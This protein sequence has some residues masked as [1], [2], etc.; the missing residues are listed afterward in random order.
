MQ[1]REEKGAGLCDMFKEP[2]TQAG[3]FL[4]LH[5]IH[6]HTHNSTE[7]RLMSLSGPHL[8]LVLYSIF[9]LDPFSNLKSYP[10]AELAVFPFRPSTF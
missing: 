6:F 3:S 10:L 2:E 8:K 9:L 5:R 1:R 7:T 4:V